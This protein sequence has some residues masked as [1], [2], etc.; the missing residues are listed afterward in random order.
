M[1]KRQLFVPEIPKYVV[2]DG[3]RHV[4]NYLERILSNKIIL[5]PKKLVII[6]DITDFLVSMDGE[7]FVGKYGVRKTIAKKFN[8]VSVSFLVKFEDLAIGTLQV[9]MTESTFVVVNPTQFLIVSI[10][11]ICETC[12]HHKINCKCDEQSITMN[13]SKSVN[14]ILE[15][16]VGE[17]GRHELDTINVSPEISNI[18]DSYEKETAEMVDIDKRLEKFNEIINSVSK[19]LGVPRDK[20]KERAITAIKQNPDITEEEIALRVLK[21]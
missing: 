1:S 5:D 4:R 8:Y 16:N 11:N 21:G 15:Y 17:Y 18:F 6:P 10:S 12:S 13:S 20:A 3:P 14:D 2:E 7:L 9:K 19:T